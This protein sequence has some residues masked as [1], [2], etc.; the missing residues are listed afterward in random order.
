MSNELV[1]I[2]KEATVAKFII[3]PSNMSGCT[4]EQNAVLG[5]IVVSCFPLDLEFA[6]SHPV[7]DNGFLMVMKVRG[8]T[9]FEGEVKPS[10]P[11]RKILRQV[12][13]HCGV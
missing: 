13:D 6:G 10:A 7:E 3:L 1:R 12:K 11:C 5:G 2:S 4:S 8:K 9:S